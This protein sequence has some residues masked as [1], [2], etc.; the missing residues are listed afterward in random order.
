MDI[1]N[2]I[3]WIKLG[4]YSST[5]PTDAVTVVGVPNPTRGD[6]YLPVTVPVSAFTT[7]AETN[8]GKLLGGGIVVG[9]WDENGVK[10]ALI[11]SLTDLST[12]LPWSPVTNILI[13]PTAQSWSNGLGNTD[14]IIAQTGAPATTAYAAGIA[15]LYLGGGFTDWYLPAAWE[16]N[17]CY[18]AATFVNRILGANGFQTN[19]W[20][21]WSSTEISST[22][23]WRATFKEG[24]GASSN[25]ISGIGITSI[26]AVRIHTL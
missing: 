24:S 17:M 25:K 2:F 13:G 15:R 1:L 21:Y 4:K 12:G 26:R 7:L 3:S 10:K 19:N 8:I 16:L 23:A 6:A 22:T 9:E 5:I 18:N 11:A 20:N 14:A